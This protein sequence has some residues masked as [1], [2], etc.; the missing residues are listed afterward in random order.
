MNGYTM[1]F[2]TLNEDFGAWWETIAKYRNRDIEARN[3]YGDE[4]VM[5]RIADTAG[6]KW[7]G[8]E[9]GVQYFVRLENGVLVGFRELR[10]DEGRR[11]K[12]AEFPIYKKEG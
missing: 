11:L 2:K 1:G 9:E 5:E 7:P 10:N 8:P 6:K 3:E 4:L 12:Y